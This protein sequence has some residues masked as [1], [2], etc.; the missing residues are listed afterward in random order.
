MD[1]FP[2]ELFW[3]IM[4]TFHLLY[5]RPLFFKV[6][7]PA[8]IYKFPWSFLLKIYI[9]ALSSHLSLHFLGL[10]ACSCH[11]LFPM[12]EDVLLELVLLFHHFGFHRLNS[13]GQTGQQ[14]PLPDKPSFQALLF[15]LLNYLFT[16][17]MLASFPVPSPRVLHP[18]PPPL[19]VWEG[20]LHP[21]APASLFQRHC[22]CTQTLCYLCFFV[23]L[24]P[25]QV[26]TKFQQFNLKKW[27]CR[28]AYEQKIRTR[29]G[30][31]CM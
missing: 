19:Q 8:Y 18:I 4:H 17:Q 10:L 31:L 22:L 12:S 28:V 16:F 24:F 25:D 7:K 1:L 21:G 5:L 29:L 3:D 11:S 14:Q 20:V 13:G 9:Y 15:F 6:W 26:D 30:V 2:R 27:F 23:T